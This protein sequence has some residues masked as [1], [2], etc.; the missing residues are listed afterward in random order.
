[1]ERAAKG[2]AP[3]PGVHQGQVDQS[4]VE[5]ALP[6][7]GRRSFPEQFPQ[8]PACRPHADLASCLN[9]ST[10]WKDGPGVA[11]VGKPGLTVLLSWQGGRT[12]G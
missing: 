11:I 2:W 10:F 6:G 8:T 5:A 12:S 1:V 4:W 3:D 9:S 7:L